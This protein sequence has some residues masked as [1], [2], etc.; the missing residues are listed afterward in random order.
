MRCL[1]NRMIWREMW[2]NSGKNLEIKDQNTLEVKITLEATQ[3][4]VNITDNVLRGI[5]VGKEHNF[6]N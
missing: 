3:E 6:L 4:W 5:Q 1:E 2:Y